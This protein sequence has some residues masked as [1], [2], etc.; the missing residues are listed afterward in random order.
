MTPI[1]TQTPDST[2]EIARLRKVLLEKTRQ[3]DALQDD[4]R[5]T[6]VFQDY[7]R[8][9]KRMELVEDR[10]RNHLL[11]PIPKSLAGLYRRLKGKSP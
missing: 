9:R 4:A 8:Q 5:K 1:K 6:V 7:D 2:L 10:L 11:I 3:L